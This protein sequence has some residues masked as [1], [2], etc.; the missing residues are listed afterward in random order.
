[1]QKKHK[2]N[3]KVKQKNNNVKKK[4]GAKY[5]QLDFLYNSSLAPHKTKVVLL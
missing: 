5:Q 4:N 2:M 3:E 1:M